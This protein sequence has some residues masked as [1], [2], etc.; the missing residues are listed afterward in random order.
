MSA[1]IAT[2]SKGLTSATTTAANSITAPMKA[3]TS[4]PTSQ[5]AG[6]RHR[7]HRR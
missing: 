4:P 5:K 7:K 2:L 6:R 3:L 1:M